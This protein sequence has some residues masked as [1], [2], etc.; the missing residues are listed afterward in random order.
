[1]QEVG[2][3]TGF[4]TYQIGIQIPLFFGPELGRT[5]EA[6][7]QREIA[8]ENLRQNQ[9]QLNAEYQSMREEYLKWRNS[10][11]YYRDQAL[12]LAREQRQG[13][14]TAYREGAIDYVSFLQN[15]RDAIRIEVDSWNALGNYLDSRYELEYYLQTTN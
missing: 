15:I 12:P 7:I 14:I 8:T 3:Q 9:L 6:K 10:W 13:S 1:M 5:Q 4:Y 11:I 2:G